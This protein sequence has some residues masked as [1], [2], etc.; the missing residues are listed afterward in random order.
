MNFVRIIV[1]LVLGTIL[2]FLSLIGI[3]NI[4]ASI[5]L[6]PFLASVF[7]SLL[8]NRKLAASVLSIINSFLA[9]SLSLLYVKVSGNLIGYFKFLG[10]DISLMVIIYYLI[11]SVAW[12][13]VIIDVKGIKKGGG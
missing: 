5:I 1:S 4:E 11:M 2:A 10:R 6:A 8:I 9:L 12:A 7:P 13:V 3:A